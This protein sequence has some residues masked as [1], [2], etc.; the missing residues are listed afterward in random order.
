MATRYKIAH[1]NN[2]STII[3]DKDAKTTP[4]NDD[5]VGLVDSEASNVLKKLSWTN[6]KATL[7]TY[8]D[9]LYQTDEPI[10][11][12]FQDSRDGEV[13]KTIKIGNQT[14]M[15]DNLR[16]LPQV[17]NNSGFESDGIAENPAYGVYDYDGTDV[18]AAKLLENYD[19][20]GVLYNW[21]AVDEGDIAPSGWHIPT[22]E[23]FKTL[24]EYLGMSEAEAD[25]TDW[26]GTSEGTKLKEGGSSGFEGLLTC[27]RNLDGLFGA[28]SSST[29]FWS[30]SVSGS[31]AWGRRLNG[32]DSMVFRKADGKTFGFNVRCLKD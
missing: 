27:L 29:F 30:S 31:N 9:T 6:I 8:F 15:L 3:S 2:V 28:F 11:G 1:E 16:Y 21:Y 25:D 14:W 10:F 24:E 13:Y 23:E 32:N 26:R 19:K 4:H 7:K 22:D 20:Y 5:V 12:M 17:D 18:A